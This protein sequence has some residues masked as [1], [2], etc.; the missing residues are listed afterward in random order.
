MNIPEAWSKFKSLRTRIPEESIIVMVI[1]L[2][3]IASFGFGRLSAIESN[4]EPVR[5]ISPEGIDIT[6]STSHERIEAFSAKKGVT[7]T[8][9]TQSSG[10]DGAADSGEVVA[11]K[12]SNKYHLPWCQGAKRIN[13]A[14]KITFASAR[15]AEKAGYIPAANCPGL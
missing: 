7:Q 15:E 10:L 2:V 8:A 14:N 11:S 6:Q 3:G 1:F 9:S 13:E 5:I 12:N 4:R